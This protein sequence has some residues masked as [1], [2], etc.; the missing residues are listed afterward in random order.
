MRQIYL[1]NRF[2]NEFLP[3]LRIKYS[4]DCLGYHI[5]CVRR[6]PTVDATYIHYLR[7]IQHIVVV[8]I[9]GKGSSTHFGW[10]QKTDN[11]D[12]IKEHVSLIN[13]QF[14]FAPAQGNRIKE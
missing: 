11:C 1:E 14:K 10:L 6:Q 13:R 9:R 3:L 8:K 5:L 7:D 4:G 12:V 2:E